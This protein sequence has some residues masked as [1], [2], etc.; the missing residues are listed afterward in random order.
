MTMVTPASQR[1]K[2]LQLIVRYGEL[3][4]AEICSKDESLPRGTIYTTLVRLE[5]QKL[6]K[7]RK[8]MTSCERGAPRRHFQVTERGARFVEA[9][10]AFLAATQ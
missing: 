2:V 1:L 3:T 7:S 9:A 10:V 6:L 4:G 5:R 8:D